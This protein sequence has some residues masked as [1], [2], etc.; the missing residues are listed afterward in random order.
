MNFGTEALE[1]SLGMA[2]TVI[3]VMAI[4]L[5]RYRPY[6]SRSCRFPSLSAALFRPANAR[7]SAGRGYPLACTGLPAQHLDNGRLVLV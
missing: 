4:W 1:L 2:L 5:A 6:A 7:V 3:L